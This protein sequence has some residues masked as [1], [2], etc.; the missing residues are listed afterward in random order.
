MLKGNIVEKEKIMIID[1]SSTIRRSAE[2]FLTPEGYQV[3]PVVD[4]FEGLVKVM[5]EKPDLV[6]ID[7]V[8]PKIDGL[9]A[10]R[11][12]RRNPQFKNL[13]IIFLSSKDGEFDKARGMMMG[14]DDYLPKPFTKES[15]IA[16]V[17][18]YTA[19]KKENAV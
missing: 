18:K 13:P 11:I 15:I 17:K 10:C 6:F 8:M 14:A 2:I 3:I 12:I 1:D 9:E 16:V 5:E 19:N 7:V 4:G